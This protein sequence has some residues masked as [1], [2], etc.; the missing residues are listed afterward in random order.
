[1]ETLFRLLFQN[2]DS[3]VLILPMRNGNTLLSKLGGIH[4]SGSYP[5]YEEWKPTYVPG[6][7]EEVA[8]SYPTY[9]E[10]KRKT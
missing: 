4:P 10:W 8:S 6:V 3:R 2:Q 7:E 1:M 5:T 9:E